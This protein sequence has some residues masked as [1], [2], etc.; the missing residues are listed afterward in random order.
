MTADCKHLLACGK[1]F[2]GA[3][4]AGA[5][6]GGAVLKFCGGPCVSGAMQNGEFLS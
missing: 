5:R 1:I 2:W 4:P 6:S 3:F